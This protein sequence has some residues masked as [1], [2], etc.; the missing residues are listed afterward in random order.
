MKANINDNIIRIWNQKNIFFWLCNV[1]E[2]RL[3]Y[4]LDFWLKLWLWI[5]PHLYEQHIQCWIL[6]D[7][8]QYLCSNCH[9]F[10]NFYR[11]ILRYIRFWHWCCVHNWRYISFNFALGSMWRTKSN[12]GSMKLS[13]MMFFLH[14]SKLDYM[15]MPLSLGKEI[16]N[17]P[18]TSFPNCNYFIFHML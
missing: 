16:A 4:I 10:T 11:H 13:F 6:I 5:L 2:F 9:T 8:V 15:Y 17:F 18:Y 1:L 3:W 14:L 12:Y 7:L